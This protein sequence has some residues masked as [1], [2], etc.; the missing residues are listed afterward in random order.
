MA[1]SRLHSQ[2][3]MKDSDKERIAARVIR[4]P[5]R[6]PELIE[7]LTSDRPPIKYG[8]GKVLR[9][10]SDREPGLLY[11]HMDFFVGLLDHQNKILQ[12]EGIYVIANLTRVDEKKKFEKIFRR[13]FAPITGTVLITA[14]N[15]IGGAATIALAKPRLSD[16]IAKELLRVDTA[17]YKTTECRRVALGHAIQAFDSFFHQIKNKKPI[18]QLVTRQLRNPRES[19]RKKAQQFLKKHGL[20]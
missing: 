9:I 12:W 11:P 2:I 10:V 13:Y 1:T 5:Q 3:A 19:T 4:N 7:G 15:V 20:R 18:V 17:R 16:R 14:A 8:C 6:I